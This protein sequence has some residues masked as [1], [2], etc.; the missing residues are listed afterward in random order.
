ML[1]FGI[2]GE[3]LGMCVSLD[4]RVMEFIE[5]GVCKRWWRRTCDT[6]ST[7]TCDGGFPFRR[8]GMFDRTYTKL[9]RGSMN[10]VC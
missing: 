5:L 9:Q 7:D 4:E 8:V 2:V 10:V 6:K 3:H 1:K